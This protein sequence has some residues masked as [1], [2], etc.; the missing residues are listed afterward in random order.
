MWQLRIDGEWYAA[1][2]DLIAAMHA[3]SRKTGCCVVLRWIAPMTRVNPDT[4]NVTLTWRDRR[5]LVL[6]RAA[7]VCEIC[8]DATATE[9]DHIWPRSFGG[10]DDLDNL[11]AACL[12]CNRRKG[13]TAYIRDITTDR[14]WD[15]HM[16]HA[17]AAVDRLGDAALWRV[18]RER[19]WSAELEGQSLDLQETFDAAVAARS[20]RADEYRACAVEVLQF[21]AEVL[22]VSGS[23][24]AAYQPQEADS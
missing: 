15:T 4:G 23:L 2:G 8:K 18:V 3:V 1:D 19:L 7:Y 13:G 10:T 14:A 6:H 21:V 12:P 24:R 20:E 5:T 17:M 9:V 16:H 11:Q 22:G